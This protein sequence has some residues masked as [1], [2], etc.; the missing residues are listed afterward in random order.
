MLKN[1]IPR[2]VRPNT[3]KKFIL[4]RRLGQDIAPR[5]LG[6]VGKVTNEVA[7]LSDIVTGSLSAT[8]TLDVWMESL[9]V[10]GLGVSCTDGVDKLDDCVYMEDDTLIVWFFVFFG[11]DAEVLDG[12]SFVKFIVNSVRTKFAPGI[13]EE[14]VFPLESELVSAL[15]WHGRSLS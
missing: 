4:R 14:N 3:I 2:I 11:G 13:S 7:I 12:I 9:D 1:V 6:S 10:E 15:S 5:R 8:D